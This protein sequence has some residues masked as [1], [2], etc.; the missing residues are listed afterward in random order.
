[1]LIHEK[2]STRSTW[3]P[4]GVEVW[5]LDPA[6]EHYKCYR[7]CAAKTRGERITDTI[8]FSPNK[9]SMPGSSTTDRVIEVAGELT[10]EIK[11][12]KHPGLIQ[13]VVNSKL[14][15]LHKLAEIFNIETQPAQT[16]PPVVKETIISTKS[17]PAPRVKLIVTKTIPSP[18]VITPGIT[19]PSKKIN[20]YP[21]TV[22]V[23]PDE[24][25]NLQA[26]MPIRN[27]NRNTPHIIP[28]DDIWSKT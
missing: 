20:S 19:Q 26:T 15:A 9:F 14:A 2:I 7:V 1:M 25:N 10:D 3:A 23:I 21:P 5:Y 4:H 24:N 13:Q 16:T 27:D 6:M 12:F 22:H 11:N 8:Q 18:R 28:E 17:G